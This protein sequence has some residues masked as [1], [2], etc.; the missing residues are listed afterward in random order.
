MAFCR[1]AW[2]LDTCAVYFKSA[3]FFQKVFQYLNGKT[4]HTV[5][6]RN[7]AILLMQAYSKNASMQGSRMPKSG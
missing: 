7:H 6:D 5:F 3:G 2:M 1:Q 4:A